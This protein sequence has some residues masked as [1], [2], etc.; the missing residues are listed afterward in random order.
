MDLI[1]PNLKLP[2]LAPAQAQKHVTHNEALRQ[3]DA[4]VQLSVLSEVNEPPQNSQNG[5]CYIV[6]AN[7]AGDFADKANNIAAF[8]DGAWAF[9]SPNIGWRSYVQ[10]VSEFRVFGGG[11]WDNL[12]G[13]AASDNSVSLFGINTTADET[14]RLAVKSSATLLDDEEHGHQLKIN[15][16]NDSDMASLLFQSGYIGR[17][18]IGLTGDTDLHLKTSS[19]GQT[20]R[21][22]LIADTETGALKT[23]YGL[24][25]AIMTPPTLACGG[26]HSF[27]GLPSAS[28]I[29]VGRSNLSL[30]SGRM[31]FT[32]VYLDRESVLEGGFVTQHSASGDMGAIMR[33]GLY[34]LGAANGNA[35][36]IGAL[37][38]DFGTAPADDEGHK[39]F[40]LSVPVTLSQG[41][42]AFAVGVNGSGAAVRYVQSRQPGLGYVQPYGNGTG[43]DVRFGGPTSYMLD[44]EAFGEI[45]NGL[46][47][48]W[49]SN[50][51]SIV[52]AV[53][54]YAYNIFIPKW[55]VWP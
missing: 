49:P 55:A 52:A 16:S 31:I 41:W 15:K 53:N 20:F 33:C 39:V 48:I 40:D 29:V 19:D 5:D 23:P 50:P 27:Y 1:S 3:L 47:T 22:V 2:Y 14:N 4:I 46:S 34:H 42:Y 18:E 51:I 43:S 6:G 12:S 17:A 38:H 36:D 21:D 24:N 44:S 9:L 25:P 26:P 45:E 30:V 8:Q 13:N 35:W 28:S 7:P 32:A 10:D 37:I 11:T 54:S